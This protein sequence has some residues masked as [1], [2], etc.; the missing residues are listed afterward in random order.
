MKNRSRVLMAG[1]VAAM[2]VTAVAV[3]QFGGGRS[4]GRSSWSRDVRGEDQDRSG[5]PEW[6]NDE[7]FKEDVFTFAR[8]RYSSYRGYGRR[9]T[10]PAQRT[11]AVRIAE[12]L[13]PGL[14]R[15]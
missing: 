5:V 11:R 8:V 3:A 1:F 12:L 13:T 2:I 4:R 14:G 7:R 9:V 10:E 15:S 6:K